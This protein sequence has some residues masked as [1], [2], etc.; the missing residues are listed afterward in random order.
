MFHHVVLLSNSSL[1]PAM[2]NPWKPECRRAVHQHNKAIKLQIRPVGFTTCAAVASEAEAVTVQAAAS[3]GPGPGPGSSSSS[4]S[5]SGSSSNG[6]RGQAKYLT[7]DEYVELQQ[8]YKQQQAAL[9]QQGV[10][11]PQSTEAAA[12]QQSPERSE[13]GRRVPWNKGRK[14]SARTWEGSV[15][16]QQLHAFVWLVGTVC[17]AMVCASMCCA[18]LQGELLTLLYLQYACVLS[19]GVGLHLLLS[20]GSRSSRCPFSV[21]QWLADVTAT[22]AYYMTACMIACFTNITQAAAVVDF[23]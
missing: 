17:I 7:Y 8:Q 3:A 12:A 22:H 10:V 15:Y 6:S 16:V 5:S 19:L 4:S 18:S 23:S 2:L 1:D 20:A 9:Q 14:H 21:G 11:Q 13:D